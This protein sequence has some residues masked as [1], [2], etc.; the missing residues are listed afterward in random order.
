MWI[1][2]DNESTVDISKNKDIIT[3]LRKAEQPIKLKGI[4]G[5]LTMVDQEGDL[6]GYGKV[7]YHPK[8]MANV[9]S[10]LNI[11]KRFMS[12][13]YD[14][15]VRDVFIITRDDRSSIEFRPSDAGL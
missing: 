1:L 8:V 4:E 9:N 11:M 10:F 14:N 12:V 15:T 2:C 7:N 5:G 3:N 6:L 13:S